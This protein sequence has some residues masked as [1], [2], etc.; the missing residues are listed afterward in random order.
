MESCPFKGAEIDMTVTFSRAHLPGMME[1]MEQNKWLTEPRRDLGGLELVE[2]KDTD[3]FY[4]MTTISA[5]D[6]R[7][8]SAKFSLDSPWI[9]PVR[10][11]YKSPG[12]LHLLSPIS[13]CCHLLGRVQ[14]CR[15]VTDNKAQ[16]YAAQ[17]VC[18][19]ESLHDLN[20][21]G[22][23]SS[24]NI[25]LDV[26][27]NIRI[28]T[29]RLFTT[30]HSCCLG[31]MAYTAPEILSGDGPSQLTDWWI[32]GSFLHEIL[33]GLPPFYHQDPV[34]RD[35][36][37]LMEELDVPTYVQGVTADILRRLLNKNPTQRLGGVHGVSEIKK[38]DFFVGLDWQH[39]S[40]DCSE[41]SPF[42]PHDAKNI[43][44]NSPFKGTNQPPR[45]F[46]ESGGH[47]YEE[48]PYGQLANGRKPEQTIG[49]LRSSS[50]I[51]NPALSERVHLSPDQ[52]AANALQAD[53]ECEGGEPE[54]IMARLKAALQTK[55]STE[56][57][58]HILDGCASD[59]LATILMSPILLV[60]ITPIETIAPT[61]LLC[62][63]PITAL[64]W[65]VELG[66]ADL[67]LLLLDRGADP[68]RT[69]DERYGPA[70]T[71]AARE[72]RTQLVDIL[73]PKT[74]RILALRTL[75]LAVEQR[76]IPTVTCL[77]SRGV[78]CDFDTTDR[79]LPPP[80]TSHYDLYLCGYEDSPWGPSWD[81]VLPPVVRAAR[82][83][84]AAMVRL[85]L[86]HG[87][88]PN[89]AYHS[90][91][92]LAPEWHASWQKAAEHRGLWNFGFVCGRVVQLAMQLEHRDVVDALLE[93]GADIGLPHSEWPGP[94]HFCPTVP[95][96][97][98][99]RVTAG[100][101]EA[102]GGRGG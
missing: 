22:L 84:D 17:L 101:E 40:A 15:R 14:R 83:G 30:D 46:R 48:Y 26:F 3:T 74:S 81:F 42:Q 36:K 27:G 80:R 18:V 71:R 90:M 50:D 75:C 5:E 95:R 54:A 34:E 67:V 2:A 8:G 73:A 62:E 79:P 25:L 11:V 99:L 87:A 47:V 28:I 96:S 59:V 89:T 100:L 70:L 57:V 20:I 63:V 6:Y 61:T 77:L 33:T 1:D 19:L 78:P 51:F 16:L 52:A 45:K 64:E 21:I 9:L 49:R 4:L 7:Q 92:W 10:F 37:I 94:A 31:Q 23:L 44:K 41:L 85:L 55:Q 66:R 58:A 65:A 91:T 56:K 12:H 38:H 88:D 86:S 32:L 97:V 69:F 43:L 72:R 82:H 35:R 76:D 98:Y 102:A 60:N 39:P 24:E 53:P 29:P 68:N 13:S 93:G